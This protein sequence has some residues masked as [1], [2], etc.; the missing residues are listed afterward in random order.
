[1]SVFRFAFIAI[2]LITGSSYAGPCPQFSDSSLDVY[3]GTNGGSCVDALTGTSITPNPDGSVNIVLTKDGT[4][5]AS[6]FSGYVRT[7]R[8]IHSLVIT[9]DST[10]NM[11]VTVEGI[12]QSFAMSP[13]GIGSIIRGGGST[14]P[15]VLVDLQCRGDVGEISVN[16]INGMIVGGDIY[17]PIYLHRIETSPGIYHY[18][19]WAGENIIA[20]DVLGNITLWDAVLSDSI[21]RIQGRL[22]APSSTSTFN[23][24]GGFYVDSFFE[25]SEVNS[26][27]IANQ[28]RGRFVTTT[29]YGGSGDINGDF[30]ISNSLIPSGSIE[31]GRALGSAGA[32]RFVSQ[33]GIAGR[34]SINHE[35]VLPDGDGWDGVI[36]LGSSFSQPTS[37]TVLPPFYE[38]SAA[39]IGGGSVGVTPFATHMED[40]VPPLGSSAA[41]VSTPQHANY[42][43]RHYGEIIRNG[44]GDSVRLQRR[45]LCGGLVW[46][47]VTEKWEF[48]Y[49]VGTDRS[50]LTMTSNEAAHFRNGYEYRFAVVNDPMVTG[51]VLC[52]LSGVSILPGVSEYPATGWFAVGNSCPA[53][54][55]GSGTVDLADLNA[56]LA[57]FDTTGVN[58]YADANG[59]GSVDLADLNKVLSAFDSLCCDPNAL[60]G[61]GVGDQIAIELGFTCVDGLCD[62]VAT[63]S[64]QDRE[65]LFDAILAEAAKW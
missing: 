26:K 49:Q 33:T 34:I 4:S 39:S 22:G 14:A 57:A 37:G 13:E 8:R 53:D 5:N 25:C 61:G 41:F 54:F 18:G 23:A 28:V 32:I 55:D 43:I 30:L 15:V 9:N 27:V 12:N 16:V 60:M 51:A 20:G 62:S 6:S 21:I 3:I 17:G 64:P 46:E 36:R 65:D 50:V 63:M 44:S 2:L 38:V 59:D 56:V 10:Q 52:D 58:L 45:A 11:H 29:A 42:A 35:S 24:Y 7:F 31:V 47:D 19:G 48:S 1:M 40:S